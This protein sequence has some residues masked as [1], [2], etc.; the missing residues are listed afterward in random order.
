MFPGVQARPKQC[1]DGYWGERPPTHGAAIG[2]TSPATVAYRNTV[3]PPRLWT[4][5]IKT[6]TSKEEL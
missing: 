3:Q 5:E 1:A 2:L 6:I 4:T